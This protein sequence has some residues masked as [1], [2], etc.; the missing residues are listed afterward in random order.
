MG[1]QFVVIGGTSGIGSEVVRQL[2]ADTSCRVFVG[3][4]K[5][6]DI[7]SSSNICWS[8]CNILE[9]N[10]NFPVIQGPLDGLVYSVGTIH[11]KPFRQLK[12]ADFIA[13][14]EV[15]VLG[16]IKTIQHYLPQL[17]EAKGASVVAFSTVAVSQGMTFH[18]S[19]A[20]A[21]A[22]LEGLF[23]SLAAEY[24][25]KIRFNLI[26]PSLTDTPLASLLLNS[27]AKREA[28]AKRQPLQRVGTASELASM[29]VFLLGDQSSWM[30]GQVLHV[31][32]GLST[33]R[34]F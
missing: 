15:N 32:G 3:S 22:A 11:L 4:R 6:I 33:L 7:H 27:D 29:A 25:P 20:S 10:P 26:A 5:E 34:L 13:D 19:T 1:K 24:A 14:F 28:A 2:A 31:D 30:S 9:D 8:C 12:T 21:K 17:S 18:A 16:A 23:R